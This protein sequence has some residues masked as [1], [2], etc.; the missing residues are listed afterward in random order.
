[1]LEQRGLLQRPADAADVV[2]TIYDA[3]TRT[4]AV[5]ATAALRRAGVNVD[6]YAGDSKLK[7]QLKYANARGVP[8][9]VVIGP[10]EVEQGVWAVKDMRSGAQ[11]SLAPADAVAH[12]RSALDDASDIRES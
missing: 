6:L 10:R 7:Q 11:S 12:I 8:F 3:D 1:V 4:A 9:V 2:V 5:Q